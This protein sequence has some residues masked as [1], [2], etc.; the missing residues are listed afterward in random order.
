MA[1]DILP[2]ANEAA[3]LTNQNAVVNGTNAPCVGY[4]GLNDALTVAGDTS[5]ASTYPNGGGN[6]SIIAYDGFL[7]FN[8]YTPGVTTQ[9]PAKPD[10][11]PIIKGQYSLWSYECMEMANTHTSDTT[12]Q[13]YTNFV[14]QIDND[15]LQSELNNGNSSTYGPV[16]AIRLSEMKCNRSSVGGA[17]T[18]N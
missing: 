18:P 16:T 6:C 5:A 15:V 1:S 8:G 7:P 14:G 12:Y 10:F 2:A 9:V 17:I 4:E 3:A 11:T 13:Y